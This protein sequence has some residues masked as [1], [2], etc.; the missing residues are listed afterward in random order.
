[1]ILLIIW[2]NKANTEKREPSTG[3]CLQ[4]FRE[5]CLVLTLFHWTCCIASACTLNKEPLCKLN[6]SHILIMIQIQLLATVEHMLILSVWHHTQIACSFVRVCILVSPSLLLA[7]A[8]NT[9]SWSVFFSCLIHLS[10][11]LSL[12]FSLPA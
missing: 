5:S 11:S 2:P 10:H 3:N 4:N 12:S 1:M 7:P 9:W 8:L 6:S